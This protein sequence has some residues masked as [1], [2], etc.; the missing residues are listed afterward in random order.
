MH[1][2]VVGILTVVALLASVLVGATPAGADDAPGVYDI[3]PTRTLY[4]ASGSMTIAWRSVMPAESI[5]TGSASCA[6]SIG[7]DV[8]DIEVCA[9]GVPFDYALGTIAD[10]ATVTIEITD[11]YQIPGDTL[12]LY[13]VVGS[14]TTTVDG[15]VPTASVLIM[16]SGDGQVYAPEPVA[17][18][19]P[20]L[21]VLAW[22]D[23]VAV[24]GGEC[25]VER[26]SP[27]PV[28]RVAEATCAS[29]SGGPRAHFT[30]P[31]QSGSYRLVVSVTDTAGNT[32]QGTR[33]FSVDGTAPTVTITAGPAAGG[34]T[35]A[36]PSWSWTSDDTGA[37]YRCWFGARTTTPVLTACTSPFAP[38]VV[39]E[40]DDRFV[41][42]ATDALGNVSSIA[43]DVTVDATKPT[44]SIVTTDLTATSLPFTIEVA[45]SEAVTPW[46]CRL[47][48]GAWSTCGVP[49]SSS[50]AFTVTADT[51]GSG[52]HTL[53]VRGLDAVGNL[54]APLTVDFIV[55][56]T[57]LPVFQSGPADGSATNA[58][59]TWTWTGSL[60]G[61]TYLCSFS[62]VG[63]EADQEAC[64][65]P[66]TAPNGTADGTY[67][68]SVRAWRSGFG[69]GTVTRRV[70]LDR[71]APAVA[72]TAG[73][74]DG[75]SLT[76]DAVTFAFTTEPGATLECSTG[77]PGAA[78]DYRPC[79]SPLVVPLSSEGAHV[80][81]VRAIDAA[82]NVGDAVTRTVFAAPL[83]GAAS[84][85]G[86]SRVGSVLTV[87]GSWTPG[88][89]LDYRWTRDG[90]AIA[91]ASGAAY[92]PVAADLAHRIG[93]EVTGKK[94]GFTARTIV[95]PSSVV[96][97]GV[98]ES[99]AGRISARVLRV[100]KRIS[101]SAGAWT[102]GTAVRYQW[103]VG[104]TRIRKATKATIVLTRAMVGKRLTVIM[105]GSRS[106]YDTRTVSVKTGRVRR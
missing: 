19:Y 80:V 92:T 50:L 28:A 44:L 25:W 45:S 74:A 97:A 87:D 12:L 46:S 79:S 105:R 11:F 100:G 75:T 13:S 54:S 89:A 42:E 94:A 66:F 69:A 4:P 102:P 35:D 39:P 43:R 1:R 88:V 98:I 10:T 21:A 2:V 15:Q 30:A 76:D 86:T 40:G 64:T 22:S 81:A 103:Y 18:G 84:I 59:P 73:P 51:V 14:T 57:V 93:V 77:A 24:Q 60:D 52:T 47:D 36:H 55:D 34:L 33:D 32:G 58:L 41:I 27:A 85:S 101:A 90:V 49:G 3:A 48:G 29:G 63:V 26:L 91:G 106:G 20:F 62:A 38:S 23:N 96:A 104:G 78:P 68:L 7:G 8:R 70:I 16:L 82:G 67:E 56:V 83:G 53:T 65:S 72:V 31:A 17:P 9:S 61:A 5:P 95:V 6:L 99:G 37:G 71:T